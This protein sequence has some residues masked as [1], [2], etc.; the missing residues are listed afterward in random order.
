MNRRINLIAAIVWLPVAI[1]VITI[2]LTGG[3]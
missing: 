3:K 2:C 1:V